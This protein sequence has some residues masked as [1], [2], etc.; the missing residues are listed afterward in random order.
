MYVYTSN[1]T[2]ELTA[3]LSWAKF[4]TVCCSLQTTDFPRCSSERSFINLIILEDMSI[5]IKVCNSFQA[6][7]AATAFC[8]T[9]NR[10]I[11]MFLPK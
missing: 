1:R 3:S 8:S 7:I 5:Y 4:K 6:Q 11:I 2:D 10:N 9:Y